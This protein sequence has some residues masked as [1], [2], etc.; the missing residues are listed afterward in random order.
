MGDRTFILG[1]GVTGLAAGMASGLPVL[2]AA[3][4]PGGVCCSY[5]LVPGSDRPLPGPPD[6]DTAYRFEI[7]GGHW[8]FG[9]EPT[10]LRFIASLGPVRRYERRSAVYFPST[11]QNVPYPIQNH[12]RFFDRPV[13]DAALEEMARP[14]QPASTMAGW[15]VGSF[16]KTLNRIFF[17]PFHDLYTAS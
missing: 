1:G 7:G 17:A 2:E 10:V 14:S 6:D 3:E 5:Y 8:L 9:G 16:G 15:L 4:H 13:I 12:L 11:R